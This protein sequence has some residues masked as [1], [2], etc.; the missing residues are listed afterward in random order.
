MEV[1]GPLEAH[2]AQALRDLEAADLRRERRVLRWTSPTRALLGEREVVVFGS[3]DYL[4]LARRSDG[5]PAR[6]ELSDEVGAGAS[7]LVTGTTASHEALE[8]EL[9]EWLAAPSALL[10]NSGYHANGGVFGALL[11]ERDVVFSDALNHASLIDG[12]RLCRARRVVFP[13]GDLD[14]L[15]EGLR[16]A[17]G[18]RIKL[19][20]CES[21][22]SM[23]GDRAPLAELC[24]LARANQAELLVDEAHAIGVFGDEGQGLCAEEGIASDVAVRVGTCGKALGSFGA[25]V[26]G[27]ADL[28]EIL[29]NRARSFVFTTALPPS[30]VET[31]RGAIPLVREPARRARLWSRIER[32]RSGLLGAGLIPEAPPS[33]VIPVLVG[34]AAAALRVSRALLERGLLVP[35]I[36]PPTVPNGTARLRITVSSENGVDEIDALVGA[37]AEVLGKG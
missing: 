17:K 6:G 4:G 37:L 28:C 3:N 14:A 34:E 22:Y 23:D 18:A 12:M 20:V 26:A 7:R 25:F 27:S 19:I 10:F 35:A 1:A 24:E 16:E 8:H 36:R 33:P 15:R 5:V 11:D 13:H 32:L 29:Y 31:T 21:I 9:A 2:L 30:V